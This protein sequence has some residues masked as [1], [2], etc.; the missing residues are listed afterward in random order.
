MSNTPLP[1]HTDTDL[2]RIAY[3]HSAEFDWNAVPG[4]DARVR[5][6][7]AVRFPDDPLGGLIAPDTTFA[8]TVESFHGGD[9][10]DRLGVGDSVVRERVFDELSARIGCGHDDVYDAWLNDAA[11]DPR[12]VS[13]PGSRPEQRFGIDDVEIR[14]AATWPGGP[15]I[16]S[17]EL[18]DGRVLGHA[19]PHE[20][21][22]L[23]RLADE[24]EWHAPHPV[25]G[26]VAR[27]I[28]QGGREAA[29]LSLLDAIESTLPTDVPE[30]AGDV[31][32][33]SLTGMDLSAAPAAGPTR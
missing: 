12:L 9:V 11:L 17:A 5:D 13:D 27:F 32:D 15:R 6:W 31:L 29:I 2:D 18:P 25:E 16:L 22:W 24:T 30:D 23:W 7:Y 21:G 19:I 33:G 26:N 14:R 1:I 10:Y 3:E 28:D 20:S 4:M 8:Q